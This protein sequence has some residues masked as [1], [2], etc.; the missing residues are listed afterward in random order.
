MKTK[1]YRLKLK[2]S[3]ANSDTLIQE[4]SKIEE[5]TKKKE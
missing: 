2:S 1:N 4:I 5:A 3:D